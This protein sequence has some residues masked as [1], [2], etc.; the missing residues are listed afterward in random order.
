MPKLKWPKN[1][2]E[3]VKN[4]KKWT[5]FK[6]VCFIVFHPKEPPETGIGHFH[7]IFD[8][9]YVKKLKN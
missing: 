9:K 8:S 4:C 1:A 2:K 3:M 5:N 6:N 7:E